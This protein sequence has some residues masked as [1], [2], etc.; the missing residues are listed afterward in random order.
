M[1][2]AHKNAKE[3]CLKEEERMNTVFIGTRLTW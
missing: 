2:K 3:L 1:E